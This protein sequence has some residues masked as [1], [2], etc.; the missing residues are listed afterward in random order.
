MNNRKYPKINDCNSLSSKSF[1]DGGIALRFWYANFWLLVAAPG[2]KLLAFYMDIPDLPR[3]LIVYSGTI[4]LSVSL[5]L[6]PFVISNISGTRTAYLSLFIVLFPFLLTGRADVEVSVPVLVG[7]ALFSGVLS[8][9]TVVYTIQRSGLILPRYAV[10]SA[11]ISLPSLGILPL[12]VSDIDYAYPIHNSLPGFV[13]VRIYGS[14]VAISIV[15]L[16][17]ASWAGVIK[18]NPMH[19]VGLFVAVALLVAALSWSGS[20]GALVAVLGA[21]CILA[22]C[23]RRLRRIDLKAI[24]WGC[25]AGF[26][27]SLFYPIPNHNFGLIHRLVSSGDRLSEAGWNGVST[28]RFDIWSLAIQSILERPL[29]GYG[30]NPAPML[31][32]EIGLDYRHFHNL[33]L[34]LAAS[35]GIPVALVILLVIFMA[36]I[37]GIGAILNDTDCN[38]HIAV[39]LGS[40][41][42]ILISSMTEGLYLS[43]F[44]S[45]IGAL[46][47]G[48]L[49]GQQ[50]EKVQAPACRSKD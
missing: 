35:F 17:A 27:G 36:L 45:A 47:V 4:Y 9:G 28:G 41:L 10:Y 50:A 20:R 32:S 38:R 18:Q 49:L 13:S 2:I 22:V 48:Q 44:A 14:I 8:I 33:P 24:L 30:F 3:F 6:M 7:Y 25:A 11:F 42:V 23:L 16:I 43:P 1:G 34:D 37:R 40:L 39:S 12:L 31:S 21:L 15:A 19:R 29:V 5:L 46:C 26:A